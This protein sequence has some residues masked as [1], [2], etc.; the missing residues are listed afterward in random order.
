MPSTIGHGAYLLIGSANV[1][2]AWPS[3]A[4]MPPAIAA[5]SIRGSHGLE[6]TVRASFAFYNTLGEIDRCVDAVR[7][8]PS[9]NGG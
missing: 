2:R 8:S 9:A 1:T 3:P 4:A 6:V 7:V 5:R